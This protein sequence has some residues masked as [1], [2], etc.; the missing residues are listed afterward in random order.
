MELGTGIFLAA[1]VLGLVLLFGQTKDRWNWKKIILIPVCL[2][3][4][5]WGGTISYYWASNAYEN[6]AVKQTEF[7]DIALGDSIS[8]VKFKK[9][10]PA[11]LDWTASRK[12]LMAYLDESGDVDFVIRF[13]DSN[14]RIIY[15]FN[16]C[17]WCNRIFGLGF[18]SSYKEIEEK[19]G[20][21]SSVSIEV[22]EL[23]RRIF[24]EKWNVFFTLEKSK[25]IHYGVYNSKLGPKN[26]P[27]KQELEEKKKEKEARQQEKFRSRLKREQKEA[28]RK[29]ILLQ[30][31]AQRMRDALLEKI[32]PTKAEVR[33][34]EAYKKETQGY[35]FLYGYSKG[36]YGWIKD[37]RH[38]GD[39]AQCMYDL[40]WRQYQ[41]YVYPPA[42]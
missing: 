25:V 6:R 20:D 22:D 38:C 23:H 19:L 27:T 11:K 36:Q 13:Q 31:E 4:L 39:N 37:N 32:A 26:Y 5:G 2:I 7:L 21:P 35:N 17:G 40:G 16:K 15:N 29:K 42:P 30:K 24:Y 18:G 12:D 3:V 33:Q 9:G 1:V 41:K 34:W 28:K 8:D 10:E 14:V